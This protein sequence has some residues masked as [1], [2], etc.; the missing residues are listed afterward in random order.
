MK[1]WARKA[2]FILLQP[3]KG[4]EFMPSFLFLSL[5]LC[6]YVNARALHSCLC[7]CVHRASVPGHHWVEAMW[8]G[9]YQSQWSIVMRALWGNF[10]HDYSQG[11]YK[12]VS[13]LLLFNEN[14]PQ[15][16]WFTGS[17]Y[18]FNLCC[19]YCQLNWWVPFFHPSKLFCMIRIW[20]GVYLSSASPKTRSAY[21]ICIFSIQ[22]PFENRLTQCL[23]IH[24]NDQIIYLVTMRQIMEMKINPNPNFV[25]PQHYNQMLELKT[26][27]RSEILSM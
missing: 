18:S 3:P 12:A 23:P 16:F 13:F 25:G 19:L 26:R 10:N 9:I 27:K 6:V 2:G 22:F 7:L 11:P 14:S 15:L 8:N 5:F 4:T 20:P 17:Q 21:S 1:W 24:Y